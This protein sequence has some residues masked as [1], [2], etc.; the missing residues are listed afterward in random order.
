MAGNPNLRFLGLFGDM[1]HGLIGQENVAIP[2]EHDRIFHGF[3]RQS[4]SHGRRQENQGATRLGQIGLNVGL[5]TFGH[6]DGFSFGI[7]HQGG[8]RLSIENQPVAR[9][10]IQP[11]DI[12]QPLRR[13]D[14]KMVDQRKRQ[15]CDGQDY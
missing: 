10:E 9:A 8:A 5:F 7:E 3:K 13:V 2:L 15:L 1:N 12:G 11:C 6:D 4:I 14:D